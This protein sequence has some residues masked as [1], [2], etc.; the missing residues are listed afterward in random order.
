MMVHM[1]ASCGHD[2]QARLGDTNE[3]ACEDCGALMDPEHPDQVL[4]SVR[5]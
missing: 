2:R 1:E 3:W 4:A 5:D